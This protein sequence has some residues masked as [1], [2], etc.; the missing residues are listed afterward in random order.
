MGG[1]RGGPPQGLSAGQGKHARAHSSSGSLGARGAV[2]SRST[3]LQVALGILHVSSEAPV[4]VGK[5]AGLRRE[6]GRGANEVARVRP[7]FQQQD[8]DVRILGESRRENTPGG[9]PADDDVV[10]RGAGCGRAQ[11]E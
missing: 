9:S 5:K 11:W 8:A 7:G 3:P 1:E 2:C 6:R 10:E 4:D